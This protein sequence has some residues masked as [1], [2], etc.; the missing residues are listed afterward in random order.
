MSSAFD[1]AGD[2]Q[3][4]LAVRWCSRQQASR[5]LQYKFDH[6]T[7]PH[8][9]NLTTRIHCIEGPFAEERDGRR[10]RVCGLMRVRIAHAHIVRVH[11]SRIE[12]RPAL[13]T[14]H[15]AIYDTPAQVAC[16][17]RAPLTVGTPTTLAS[18][19][20]TRLGWTHRPMTRLPAL[21]VSAG[22]RARWLCPCALRRSLGS[23]RTWTR[24]D[25]ILRNDRDCRLQ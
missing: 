5:V 24:A 23:V 6:C 9:T 15:T 13:A 22:E 4:L 17:G 20:L 7:L 10:C 19:R 25:D 14:P 18:T 11:P 8:L 16:T 1:L 21:A 12:P 2:N 3:Q